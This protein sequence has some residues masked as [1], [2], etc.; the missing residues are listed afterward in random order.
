MSL[1]KNTIQLKIG[2]EMMKKMSQQNDD[3]KSQMD[4]LKQ[5]YSQNGVLPEVPKIDE[6]ETKKL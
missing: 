6:G 4:Q 5:Q 2:D 1:T 3:L